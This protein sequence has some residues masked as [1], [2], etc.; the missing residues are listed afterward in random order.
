MTC[1]SS[2]SLTQIRV[3][4]SVRSSSPGRPPPEVV[5]ELGTRGDAELEVAAPGRKGT[6]HAGR[7]A[8][9]VEGRA[10]DVHATVGVVDPVD[11]YLVDAEPV[12]LGEDEELGVEEPAVVLDR[13][14]EAPGDVG[15]DGLEPALGVADPGR[16]HR[17]GG[18]GCRSGR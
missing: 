15:A 2:G 12:V 5:L 16:E 13:R 9:I 10:G 4:A 18:S 14:Q 1:G 3:T 17:R 8:E 11:R 7:A 6:R